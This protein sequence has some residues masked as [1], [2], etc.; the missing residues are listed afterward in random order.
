MA[1]VVSP[2]QPVF[3]LSFYSSGIR[4]KHF[5]FLRVGG[6]AAIKAPAAVKMKGDSRIASSALFL[7]VQVHLE[8]AGL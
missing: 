6:G 3:S 7:K 8:I 1:G 2:R 5:C 4:R